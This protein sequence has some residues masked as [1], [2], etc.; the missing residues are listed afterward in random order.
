MKINQHF[1][2]RHRTPVR[3]MA[4]GFGPRQAQSSLAQAQVIRMSFLR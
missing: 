3:L 2:Q 1:E 4:W